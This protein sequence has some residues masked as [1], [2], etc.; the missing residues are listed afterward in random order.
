MGLLTDLQGNPFFSAGLNQPG[1]VSAE[2]DSGDLV[3]PGTIT[4]TGG[5][6]S[7]TMTQRYRW[8]Q[9]GKTVTVY[10]CIT[11]TVAGVLTTGA[12][13]ALP[14]S[15]PVPSVLSNQALNSWISTGT[16]AI[17]AS[18]TGD[19]SSS[20]SGLFRDSGGVYWLKSMCPVSGAI[21]VTGNVTYLT[22]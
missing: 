20:T 12:Q 19:P 15:C 8:T 10:W 21:L 11:A 3:L 22:V 2:F 4:W 5:A 1:A 14:A 13:I 7:G 18:L 16:G 6:P 9:V 17:L